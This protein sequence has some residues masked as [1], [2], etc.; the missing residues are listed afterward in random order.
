M[1]QPRVTSTWGEGHAGKDRAVLGRL[2]SKHR[3]WDL[4]Y[5]NSHLSVNPTGD[6]I[7]QMDSLVL[8][9]GR[10]G[11]CRRTGVKLDSNGSGSEEPLTRPVLLQRAVV[12]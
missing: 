6:L 3:G 7:V 2:L 1:T 4:W 5:P 10:E 12:H 11:R 9:V 8:S